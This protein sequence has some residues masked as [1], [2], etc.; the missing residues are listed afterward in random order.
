VGV[1]GITAFRQ[2]KTLDNEYL[3]GDKMSRPDDIVRGLLEEGDVDVERYGGRGSGY[4]PD[5]A[6]GKIIDMI[7]LESRVLDVGCGTGS[8]T[9][10]IKEM[11][12]AEVVGIEPQS[13]RDQIALA[14]GLEVHVCD[15]TEEALNS[16]APFDVIVFADVL[17]HLS[18]PMAALESARR[19]LRNNGFIIASIPN[20]AHWTVRLNLL[21]GRFNYEPAGIMDASH[22][23]WFTKSTIEMLFQSAG[24][25][26]ETQLV[27]LGTWMY[28]YCRRRPWLWLGPEKTR[29]IVRWL[30]GNWPT[31]FGCQYIVKARPTRH[32]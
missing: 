25:Q 24:L 6:H 1:S 13:E 18:N 23:R 8:C 16:I 19:G 27:S 30:A 7:P 26:I 2:Q 32:T 28:T 31:V 5:E 22:L 17:E 21:R 4:N 20:V 15:F 10:L 14:R 11:R 29:K 9:I 3:N 12:D